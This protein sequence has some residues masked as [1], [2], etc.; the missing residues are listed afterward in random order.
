MA[1]E[2][3]LDALD[4]QLCKHSNYLFINNGVSEE[5]K[6]PVW[7]WWRGYTAKVLLKIL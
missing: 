1:E 5:W 3:G 4:Q 6:E 7:D 2:K